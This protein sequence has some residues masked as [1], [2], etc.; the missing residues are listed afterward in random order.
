MRIVVFSHNFG[1]T[2]RW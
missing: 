2:S 1:T